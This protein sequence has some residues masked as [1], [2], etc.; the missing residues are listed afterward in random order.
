M[1]VPANT[2]YASGNATTP[3]K[4][5]ELSAQVDKINDKWKNS[6]R[7]IKNG[8][9]LGFV[10]PS[11]IASGTQEAV[12]P[13]VDI[14]S[15]ASQIIKGIDS[16]GVKVPTGHAARQKHFNLS[17][18]DYEKVRSEVNRRMKK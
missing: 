14:N 3:S 6:I 9:Y 13:I 15:I 17:S 4:N 2:L 7:L 1:R 12:R 8:V 5:R 11:D 18:A 10:R 16:N